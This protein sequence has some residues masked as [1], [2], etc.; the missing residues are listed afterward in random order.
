MPILR[1]IMQ[2]RQLSSFRSIDLGACFKQEPQNLDMPLPGRVAQGCLA[3]AVQHIGASRLLQQHFEGQGIVIP[4]C[5][6]D[7]FIVFQVGGQKSNRTR[8]TFTTA[9]PKISSSGIS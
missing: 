6:H 7:L 4:C 5:Q 2:G 8:A 1:C 3:A 9:K